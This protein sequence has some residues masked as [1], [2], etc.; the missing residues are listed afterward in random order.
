MT[1]IQPIPPRPW[2]VTAT[3]AFI[4]VSSADTNESVFWINLDGAHRPTELARANFIV[5]AINKFA[6]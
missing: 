5:D 6:P 3:H 1:E 2:K 4:R